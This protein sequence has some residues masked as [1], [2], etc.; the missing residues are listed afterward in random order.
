[1]EQ[2]SIEH[3]FHVVGLEPG[4]TLAEVKEAYRF[5]VQTFH[6]DKYPADHPY[7]QRARDKMVELNDACERLEKFFDEN[8]TG[9]P[10]GGWPGSHAQDQSDDGDAMDWQSWQKDQQ[11]SW[12]TELSQWQERERLRLSELKHEGEKHRRKLI[13]NATR[14]AL[15][16]AFVCMLAGHAGSHNTYTTTSTL[17]NQYLEAKRQYDLATRGTA[18]GA[19]ARSDS[20]LLA[21][22]NPLL[23]KQKEQD[24]QEAQANG[25]SQIMLLVLGAFLAWLFLSAK[26]SAFINAWIEGSLRTKEG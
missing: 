1:M 20:E 10:P 22:D 13:A 11:T 16:A 14:L 21:E 15:I 12:D 24:R 9:E 3:Y 26:A 23:A 4:A 5:L 19:S 2:K 25:T 18:Q 6:E 8:P 7:R 17:D